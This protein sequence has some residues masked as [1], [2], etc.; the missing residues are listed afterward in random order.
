MERRPLNL[1]GIPSSLLAEYGLT[2][3]A[4]QRQSYRC[5]D[6]VAN[7]VPIRDILAPMG[8][9]LNEDVVRQLLNGIKGAASIPPVIVVSEGFKQQVALLDGLH[10]FRVSLALGYPMVPCQHVP[11]ET[12]K[13]R[14]GHWPRLSQAEKPPGQ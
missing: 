2:T 3:D 1:Y 14:Y 10:R 6:P 13:S 12:A 4:G 9:G 5:D 7:L 8:R 11:L